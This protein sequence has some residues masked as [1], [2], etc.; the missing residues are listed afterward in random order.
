MTKRKANSLQT[1]V[2][3]TRLENKNHS[4]RT[5]IKPTFVEVEEDPIEIGFTN[6]EREIQLV[7]SDDEQDSEMEDEEQGQHDSV[8]TSEPEDLLGSTDD[9]GQDEDDFEEE[10]SSDGAD[11]GEPNEI[12]IDSEAEDEEEM[13]EMAALNN[14]SSGQLNEKQ[15]FELLPHDRDALKELISALAFSLRK[16]ANPDERRGQPRSAIVNQLTAV[17]VKYYGYNKDLVQY[18]VQLLGPE[19]ATAFLEANEMPRPTTLRVNVLKT[20]RRDLA[21]VLISRG[22]NVDPVGDWCKEGLVVKDSTVPIGATPEY[23]AGHYMLQSASSFLPVIAL[24]PQPDERIVDMASAPGGKTTFIAQ[25]M[26]NTGV[27]YANDVNKAR[28]FALTANVQRLGVRNVIVTHC[29][30]RK[31]S[32]FASKIDRV[33]LDAPCTGMGVISKDP[34]IK[35]KRTVEDFGKQAGMQRELLNAA[36]DMVN[37]KSTKG[38]IIVYSTCSISVEENEMVIV[39]NIIRLISSVFSFRIPSLNLRKSN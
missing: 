7:S 31:L 34:S 12:L 26:R 6:K 22:A 17:C 11:M 10:Q 8:D 39:R 37:E 29:D 16:G 35:T 9:D 33:L 27:L 5:R 1:A 14:L 18:F 25:L 4:K 21:R 38:G 13:N 20:R 15:I 32:K 30:G 19:K 36:I 3:G 2:K 24:D 23:L 28:A